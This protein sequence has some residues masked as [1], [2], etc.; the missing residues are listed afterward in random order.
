MKVLESETIE[1]AIGMGKDV[2]RLKILGGEI[3]VDQRL[4]NDFVPMITHLLRN[5]I[6]HG[7]EFSYER[8][9]KGKS[10]SG[11][12]SIEIKELNNDYEIIFTDDG[13]GI[14]A[15]K[16]KEKAIEKGINVESY[17]QKQLQMLIF[18]AGF[19]TASKVST[20]SGRGVG[21]DAVKDFIESR[22]GHIEMESIV[23]KGTTFTIYL[24]KPP[25]IFFK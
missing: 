5:S 12:I 10:R 9:N 8:E 13:R 16:I 11:L 23:D 1:H 14:D 17:D 25:R 7:I 24:P 21:M 15:E 4:F 18:D 19:S 6:D 2:E 3:R 22:G 20:T